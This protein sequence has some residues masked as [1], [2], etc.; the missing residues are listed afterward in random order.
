MDKRKPV[1]IEATGFFVWLVLSRF[2]SD[3]LSRM[4]Q[5]DLG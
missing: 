1:A 3:F 4:R 2:R 5:G